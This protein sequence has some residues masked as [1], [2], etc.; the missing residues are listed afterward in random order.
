MAC[1]DGSPNRKERK[2]LKA[3]KAETMTGTKSNKMKALAAGA[4]ITCI[5]GGGAVAG[6]LPS[7]A[8]AS[9]VS[10][11]A[12]DTVGHARHGADDPIAH[13]SHSA[14]DAVAHASHADDPVAHASHSADDPIAHASQGADDP[15]AHARHGADD[16][17]GH[18]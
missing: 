3:R 12:D 8:S 5:L 11:S 18:S 17:I 16:P 4:A 9:V 1:C 15:I 13:A 14:D 10:R 6:L 2:N 7:I